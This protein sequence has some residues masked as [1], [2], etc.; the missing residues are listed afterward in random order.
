[1]NEDNIVLHVIDALIAADVPYMLVGSFS[2]NYYGIPRSTAD[3]DFVV[4]LGGKSIADLRQHLHGDLRLDPQAGFETI[5]GTVKNVLKLAQSSFTVELFRLSDDAHDQE[6]FRHRQAVRLFERDVYL[7]TAEDVIIMK[8]RWC[9]KK[10]REDIESV[11]GIQQKNLDFTYIHR[12]CAVHGTRP[13]LDEI[14]ASIPP[15]DDLE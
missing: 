7:Q 15:L 11:L 9:R 4:Q 12:W 13:L 5:T 6:R 3:A 2:S 1:M 14:Q 8:L 10:D